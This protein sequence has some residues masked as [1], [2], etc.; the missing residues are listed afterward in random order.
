MHKQA[1]LNT[2]LIV[3]AFTLCAAGFAAMMTVAPLFAMSVVGLVALVFLIRAIYQIERGRIQCE[4]S[5]EELRKL[6]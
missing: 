1:A 3:T 4:Q 5:Q 6:R 2:V